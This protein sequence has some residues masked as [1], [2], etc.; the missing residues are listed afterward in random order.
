MAIDKP[1]MISVYSN[2]KQQPT[3]RSSEGPSGLQR[4]NPTITRTITAAGVITGAIVDDT[5]YNIVRRIRGA[6]SRT[7]CRREVK[8]ERTKTKKNHEKNTTPAVR[9]ATYPGETAHTCLQLSS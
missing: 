2:G 1:T 8:Q 5:T 4:P 7:S 9:F 6:Q 3:I